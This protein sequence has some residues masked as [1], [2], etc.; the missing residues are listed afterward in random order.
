MPPQPKLT[1]YRF[2]R[3]N[4]K[5]VERLKKMLSLQGPKRWRAAANLYLYLN[6]LSLGVDPETLQPIAKIDAQTENQIILEECK[7]LRKALQL[8]G[9]EMGKSWDKTSNR[10]YALRM[11]APMLQFLQ[12]IDPDL[13]QGSPD[14]RRK[15][16]HELQVEFKEYQV[17]TRI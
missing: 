4:P 9:N 10:R 3:H 13:L 11:P 14:E 16:L 5:H 15:S 6:P 2:D 7:Q 8:S 1:N 12:L 17:L